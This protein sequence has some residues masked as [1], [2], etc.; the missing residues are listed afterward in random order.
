M[1]ISLA[2]AISTTSMAIY[3]FCLMFI[4]VNTFAVVFGSRRWCET[5][6]WNLQAL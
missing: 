2:I 6:S 4:I 5:T 1:A 3:C